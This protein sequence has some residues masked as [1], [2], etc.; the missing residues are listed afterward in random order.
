MPKIRKPRRNRAMRFLLAVVHL[1]RQVQFA[2]LAAVLAGTSY[3][4]ADAVARTAEEVSAKLGFRVADVTVEGRERT[5]RE[6]LMRRVDVQRGRAILSV[7]LDATRRR[8]EELPW[9]ADAVVLR[10][11]PDRLHIRITERAPFALFKQGKTLTLIDRSGVAITRHH[12]EGFAR[13]PVVSGAGAE[14]RAA[15]LVDMLEDYP[16]VRNRFVGAEWVNGRRWTL[17]LDHGGVVHLPESG[18]GTALTR[19]M[20]LE[21]ERRVLAEKNQA[22][23]LRLPDRILL[24]PEQK[25]SE[26]AQSGEGVS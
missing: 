20:T 23:D 3:I 19:L 6:D 26:P 22:I 14:Y 1:P 8:I 7:D 2:L 21:R 10:H 4:Y 25:R 24:R 16:V 9:V 13:L 17:H 12:L 11:L 18:V 5:R 15:A